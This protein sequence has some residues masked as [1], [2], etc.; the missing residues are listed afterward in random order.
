MLILLDRGHRHHGVVVGTK[1]DVVDA[2]RRFAEILFRLKHHLVGSAEK[3]EVVDLKAAQ[4]DLQPLEHVIDGNV[5]CADFV[6]IDIQL[7]L[8]NGGAVGRINAS[9]FTAL[10]H[11]LHE[12]YLSPRPAPAAFARSCPAVRRRIPKRCRDR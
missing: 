7:D 11:G 5:Q 1:V 6:A 12:L 9:E 8:R 2:L 3:I 10:G 4:I